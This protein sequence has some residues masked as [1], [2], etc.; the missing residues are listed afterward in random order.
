MYNKTAIKQL[1][2]LRCSF[3]ARLLTSLSGAALR[4]VQRNVSSDLLTSLKYDSLWV[5]P[6]WIVKLGLHHTLVHDEILT[7]FYGRELAFERI[8]YMVILPWC[9]SLI[10]RYRSELRWDTDFW[11]LSYD[12]LE[13]LVF[14]YKILC[15]W[16]K[17]VPRT[18]ERNKATP[19]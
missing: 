9:L 8:R 12:S 17:I 11:F 14:Q 4:L 1:I 15:H 13:S 7:G 2:L 16:L 3:I 18:R 6:P 19:L 5:I 10:T